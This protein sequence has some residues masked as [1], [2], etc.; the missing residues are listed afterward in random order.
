MFSVYEL[1]ENLLTQMLGSEAMAMES[2]QVFVHYF[3][4]FAVA[5]AIYAIYKLLVGVFRLFSRG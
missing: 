3:S 2:T 1:I 4:L 5:F